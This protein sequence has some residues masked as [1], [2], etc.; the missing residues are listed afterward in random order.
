MSSGHDTTAGACPLSQLFRYLESPGPDSLSALGH[1]LLKGV[2]RHLGEFVV[3]G[4]KAVSFHF[5]T[6]RR[7]LYLSLPACLGGGILLEAGILAPPFPLPGPH[8]CSLCGLNSHPALIQSNLV[9]LQFT[10]AGASCTPTSRRGR[11]GDSVCLCTSVSPWSQHPRV[12]QQPE[13]S[14]SFPPP[15]GVL[16]AG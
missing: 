1:S 13:F 4:G 6:E 14:C 16:Q 15:P 12:G 11:G 10:G 2:R 9:S 3:L 8:P 5:Q 7:L